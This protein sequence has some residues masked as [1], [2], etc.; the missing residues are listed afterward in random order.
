MIEIEEHVKEYINDDLIKAY[1]DATSHFG[2]KDLVLVFDETRIDDPLSAYS[3]ETLSNKPDIPKFIVHKITRPASEVK[4]TI[5]SAEAAFWFIVFFA[6]DE[7]AACVAVNA[8]CMSQ[9]G[10]A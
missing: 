7:A 4:K 1:W 5:K 3:R 10:H 8:K 6:N 9:G 2:T